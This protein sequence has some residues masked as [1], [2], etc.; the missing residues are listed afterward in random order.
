MEK[1]HPLFALV[2]ALD[3]VI[4]FAIA[5]PYRGYSH[6]RSTMSVL[7]CKESPWG[8]I[9]NLWMIL[10]GIVIALLGYAL[11]RAYLAVH[12]GL[13]W[14]LFVLLLL[15]GLGDEVVSGLFPVNGRKEDV[16][17]RVKVHGVG[18]VIGFMALL[19]APLPLAALARLSGERELFLLCL[20]CFVLG[21]TAFVCFVMGDKPRFRGTVFA[22]EGLWQRLICLF[23]YIPLFFR[24]VWRA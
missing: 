16:D 21:L 20:I 11:L 2:L 10:S 23:L 7:G 14:T 1:Y 6:I 5:I 19:F 12:T 24:L 3:I 22:L 8:R 18:S 17:W 4:P 13:A 15:Y 9:Y